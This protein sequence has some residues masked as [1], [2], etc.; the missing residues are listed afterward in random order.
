MHS[1]LYTTHSKARLIM[2][3]KPF[4]YTPLLWS[5]RAEIKLHHHFHVSW[6]LLSRDLY[7][8][9]LLFLPECEQEEVLC[10]LHVSIPIGATS[11]GPRESVHHQRHHWALPENERPSG[12]SAFSQRAFYYSRSLSSLKQARS[13]RSPSNSDWLPFSFFM[14]HSPVIMHADSLSYRDTWIE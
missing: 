3:R 10:P 9:K 13:V 1:L 7:Y 12:M 14:F 5:L 2:E 6:G 11:Y 8:N 4:R